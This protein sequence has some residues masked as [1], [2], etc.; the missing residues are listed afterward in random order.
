M[1]NK[2]TIYIGAHP[3]DVIINAS[4]TI[5][6]NPA[7][8]CILTITDGVPS[9]TYPKVLGGITLNSHEAYIQQ[10]L[11]EDKAAMEVLGI[12]AGERY[13]NGKIPDGQAYQNLEQ[14]V[15][16]IATIVKREKIRRIM[17]HSFPGESHP[18]HPDH[19]IVSVC[20]YIIGKQFGIEIWE[21]P[22]FKSN[23]T[24]KQT[25]KI[26]LQEEKMEI[27]R[28]DFGREEIAVRDELM[29][30]YITQEFIIR[31]Y[32]AT[33]EMFGKVVR[34]PRMIPNTPHFYGSGDYKP[35]RQA[36]KKAIADFFNTG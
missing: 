23:S 35:G 27:V 30:V 14:I 18:A 5:H 11:R 28:Y 7:S 10:R 9:G 15:S 16:I 24:N 20:S 8:A 34:D 2:K 21:Y 29:R 6:R 22:R 19:E 31:K 25:D 17:T 3:D 36:I 4:I 33:C 13:T 12:N 32:R 26:F 1:E